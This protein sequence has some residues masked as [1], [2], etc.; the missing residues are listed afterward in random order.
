MIASGAVFAF[1]LASPASHVDGEVAPTFR[2][3]PLVKPGPA[4]VLT[5]HEGGPVVL[6]FFASWCVP[7]R[8]ELPVLARVA[9][10]VA[11]GAAGG[12]ARETRFIGVDVED[13]LLGAEQLV[14]TAG[15]A[16]PVGVDPSG[17]VATGLYHLVGLPGTIFI[18]TGG[19]IVHVSRGPVSQGVALSWIKRIA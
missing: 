10:E 17:R 5:A 9:D 6:V 8:Q 12:P 7:C 18:G 11:N 1:A 14:K 2:L 13:S 4:V 15:V 3:S 16:Y 19:R